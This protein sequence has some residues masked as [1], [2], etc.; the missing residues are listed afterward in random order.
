MR[1]FYETYQ[2][3]PILSALLREL[4]WTPSVF[5]ANVSVPKSGSFTSAL[6]LVI[7][8]QAKP[9]KWSSRELDCQ[10]S[11]CLFERAVLNPPKVSAALQ[12]LHPTAEQV[13]KDSYLLDRGFEVFGRYVIRICD[14]SYVKK[15][16]YLEKLI[17]KGFYAYI[18]MVIP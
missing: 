10:I 12:E 3:T 6:P 2:G 8:T 9:E 18:I 17:Y 5:W 1:Q 16:E 4:L 14:P 11:S 15:I 7:G 13:F